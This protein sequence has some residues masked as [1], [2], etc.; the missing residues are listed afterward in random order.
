MF[1]VTGAFVLFPFFFFFLGGRVAGAHV[2]FLGDGRKGWSGPNPEKV[3]VEGWGPEGFGAE[4][5]GAEGWGGPKC[6]VFPLPPQYCYFTLLFYDLRRSRRG[7]VSTND[8]SPVLL[9]RL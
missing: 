8:T 4:E 3:R 5:W 1:V 2:F 6:R 9:Q 7:S